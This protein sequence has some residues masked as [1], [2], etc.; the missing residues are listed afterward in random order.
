MGVICRILSITSAIEIVVIS[1]IELHM[2]KQSVTHKQKCV[3]NH[4]TVPVVVPCKW[5]KN[6]L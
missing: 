4:A 3:G 2:A 5:A 6:N 1:A